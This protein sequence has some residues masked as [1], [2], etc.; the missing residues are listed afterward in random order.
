[1]SE[2]GSHPRQEDAATRDFDAEG[3]PLPRQEDETAGS[4]APGVDVCRPDA[5]PAADDDR[6]EDGRK[7]GRKPA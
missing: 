2:R 4:G 5:A 3:R 6:P 7:D 1:M